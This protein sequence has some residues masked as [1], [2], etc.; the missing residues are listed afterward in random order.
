MEVSSF[1][2]LPADRCGYVD[3]DETCIATSWHGGKHRLVPR[4]WIQ[5][6]NAGGG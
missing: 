4:T 6:V 3:G 2:D 1:V 5:H